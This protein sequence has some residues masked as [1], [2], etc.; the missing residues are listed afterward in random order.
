MKEKY[1]NFIILD[2]ET[3]GKTH[4][5]NPMTQFASIIIDGRS[6]NEVDRYCTFIKQYGEKEGLIIEQEALDYTGITRTQIA[7]G[8][9]IQQFVDNFIQIT[10]K[11]RAH[12][13]HV[14]YKPIVVGHNVQFDLGFLQYAFEY[15]KQDLYKYIQKDY[16]C[17]MRMS[18]A[19]SYP[20][21]NELKFNLEACCERMSVE[22]LDG[23]D[24]MNDTLATM[25]LFIK[26]IYHLR[27]DGSEGM[28]LQDTRSRV[29]DTFKFEF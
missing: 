29:R 3:G 14:A 24:A 11:A 6:L 22:L 18:Q 5:K 21:G 25:E 10:T 9:S 2:C 12:N 28:E 20:Q 23:H 15:C 16:W 26:L 13:T 7:S 8:I 17:T 27:G 4:L 1:C 19:R